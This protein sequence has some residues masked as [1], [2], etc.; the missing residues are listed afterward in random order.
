MQELDKLIAQET[1]RMEEVM[2]LLADPSFYTNEEASSDVI[3]EHAQL[4]KSLSAHEEEWIEL[5]ELIENETKKYA[6]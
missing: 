3:A 4:K 2:A 6:Q 5:S 1:A